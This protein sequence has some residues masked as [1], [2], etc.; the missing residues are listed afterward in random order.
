[1]KRERRV[2]LSSIAFLIAVWVIAP[3]MAMASGIGATDGNDTAGPLDL[4]G[5]KLTEIPTGDRI[6]IR[7]IAAFT[8]R[9]LDGVTGAMEVLVDT[10]ADGTFDRWVAIYYENGKLRGALGHK[11]TFDRYIPARRVDARSVAVDIRHSYLGRVSSYDFA[12]ASYWVGAP[13]SSARPCFDLIPN[14]GR[15][16][17]HDW[18]APKVTWTSIPTFSSDASPTLTFPVTFKVADDPYGAGLDTWTLQARPMGGVWSD[19]KSGSSANPTV[20][21]VGEEGIRYEFRVIA[22]DAQGNIMKSLGGGTDVP[23]DDRNAIFAYSVAPTLTD[24]VSDAFLG[25]TSLLP[26]DATITATMPELRNLCVLGGPTSAGSTAQLQLSI[27]GVPYTTF[28]EGDST[29]FRSQNCAGLQERL[30]AG[31]EITLKVISEEP[32][33]FDGLVADRRPGVPS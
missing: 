15:L 27:D 3:S 33:V 14:G 7:S 25:T 9:Q 17:R 20:R 10:N 18:T 23:W 28:S 16:L 21:V 5:V 2:V 6:Q 12:A 1:M 4:A 8:V 31:T 30:P 32:F 19:I 29:V 26:I 11:R 13:C 22:V 24:E